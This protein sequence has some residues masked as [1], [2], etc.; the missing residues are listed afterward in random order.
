MKVL[1]YSNIN[2]DEKFQKTREIINYFLKQK[3]DVI[4]TD[5]MYE[6]FKDINVSCFHELIAKTIDMLFVL[7]GDG[8]FLTAAH[9]F[10]K[11]QI[12]FIGL[13][14]GRVGYLTECD[15]NNYFTT[16]D[17]VLKGE[18]T[19][20]QKTLLEFQVYSQNGAKK[21]IGFNDVVIHRGKELQ[22]LKLDIKVKDDFMDSFYA[23]GVLV[24]T[25]MGSTAYNLSAGGPLLLEGSKSFVITPICSQ[26]GIMPSVVTH[27]EDLIEITAST[28]NDSFSVSVDGKGQL[29]IPSGTTMFIS[30]SPM[31]LPIVSIN[32]KNKR[33]NHIV[34]VFNG[35]VR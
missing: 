6:Y 27:D 32:E 12:P 28:I 21:I 15:M 22:M 5:T 18:Y 1:V 25:C 3:I 13:N 4:V 14:L 29:E 34:K 24:S 11:Y 9:R 31:T 33:L 17:K 16:I 8:T 7:G 20:K 23:D 2:K 19:V 35:Y 26:S 10:Y 30:K